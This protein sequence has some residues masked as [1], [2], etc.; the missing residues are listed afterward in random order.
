MGDIYYAS[1]GIVQG[2]GYDLFC[3]KQKDQWST[4]IQMPAPINSSGDDLMILFLNHDKGLITSNRSG[5]KG[6]DDIYLFERKR[7]KAEE[8]HFTARLEYKD[9]A[10]P[11]AHILVTNGLKETILDA[12]TDANGSISLEPLN[13]NEH[14]RLQVAGIQPSMYPDCALHIVDQ[15][16][17]IVKTLR[18]NANGWVDLELL[19]F[20]YSTLRLASNDDSSILTIE[21]EGQVYSEKPGD[22]GKGE[23]V[24]IVDENGMPVAIAYTNEGGSFKFNQLFPE[25]NYTFKLSEKSRAQ[26]VILTDKGKSITLPV[27]REE[28]IYRRID[29]S[30]AIELVNEN[31]ETIYIS[32]NDLFVINR[33][34]YTSNSAQ[35]TEEAKGQLDQLIIIL[36]NNPKLRVELLSH[37]DARGDEQ[38]NLQLSERRAEAAVQYL[39]THG[40]E[41]SRLR[42]KGLGESQLINH[43][44]DGEN[45][46]DAE[47]AINRRTEIKLQPQ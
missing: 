10:L 40:I 19:P 26:Q 46:S 9:Q 29:K 1:N 23:P 6:K 7:S 27:L 25:L 31:N 22:I 43:C 39:V 33:I 5:G 18:L 35:L 30:K 11:G 37:T 42:P 17:R 15:F 4:S 8:H 28:A 16:G 36:K 2:A 34:Y 13:L 38:D 20:D 24:T 45:C 14:Y 12:N 32:P 41:R 21:L 3:A 44:G 47:H